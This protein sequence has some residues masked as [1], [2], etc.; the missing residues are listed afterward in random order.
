M[1]KRRWIRPVARWVTK[2]SGG[3]MSRA[4]YWKGVIVGGLTGVLS[5]YALGGFV[6]MVV[7][8]VGGAQWWTVTLF[9]GVGIMAALAWR[10]LWKRRTATGS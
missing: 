9:A 1:L 4:S 3:P 2:R 6:M 8:V 7:L 10:W 5:G